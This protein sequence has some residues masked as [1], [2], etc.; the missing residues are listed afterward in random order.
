M[1]CR[2]KTPI[3]SPVRAFWGWQPPITYSHIPDLSLI[4]ASHTFNSTLNH[5]L[6]HLL[7]LP[8]NSAQ[9]LQ[10][11]FSPGVATSTESCVQDVRQAGV[12]E[13]ENAHDQ[14]PANIDNFYFIDLIS[15]CAVHIFCSVE[16]CKI[17]QFERKIENPG[18]CMFDQIAL[19][20]NTCLGV[21]LESETKPAKNYFKTRFSQVSLGRTS[22][23]RSE[24][25]SSCDTGGTNGSTLQVKL[26]LCD[27]KYIFEFS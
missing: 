26:F 3:R 8:P 6:S 1:R 22:E 9:P 17:D 12:G 19:S 24:T 7:L 5:Q 2:A 18:S 20:H 4:L 14:V 27:G 11:I 16:K 25:R 10:I 15:D 13:Q 23:G 21:E